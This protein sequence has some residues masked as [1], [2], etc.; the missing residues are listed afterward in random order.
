MFVFDGGTNAWV[1]GGLPFAIDA[2]LASPALD[3][4]CRPYEGTDNSLQAMQAYL[5]WDFGLV[6]QLE[7]DGTHHFRVI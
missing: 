3:C 1:A 6:E 5:D 4:Y 2:Q 7:R